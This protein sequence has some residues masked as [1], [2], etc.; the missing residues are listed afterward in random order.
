MRSIA[1]DQRKHGGKMGPQLAELIEAWSDQRATLLAEKAAAEQSAETFRKAAELNRE[2]WAAAERARD[3]ARVA[4]ARK[5]HSH[6]EAA[7]IER[8]RAAEADL[9]A[10]RLRSDEWREE[11]DRL[12]SQLVDWRCWASVESDMEGDD[13]VLRSAISEHIASLTDEV[14]GARDARTT[15]TAQLEEARKELDDTQAVVLELRDQID[16]ANTE[17]LAEAAES[18]LAALRVAATMVQ[19]VA[20]SMGE[21]LDPSTWLSSTEWHTALDAIDSALSVSPVPPQT[22]EGA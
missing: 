4:E 18:Q 21:S 14:D 10:A 17:N 1:A 2:A 5:K 7:L 20:E 13:D 3:E 8:V 16:E 15:L 11:R 9:P 22:K 12:T 19:T 6:K